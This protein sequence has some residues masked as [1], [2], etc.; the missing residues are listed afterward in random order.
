MDIKDFIKNLADLYEDVDVKEFSP[1]T[2]FKNF[3]EWSSLISLSI[4][5]MA[6]DEYGVTL[7]G[8]DIR[9]ANTVQEL[10][11]IVKSKA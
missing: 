1:E 4:V 3:E 11:D 6:E 8:D 7:K 9:N 2:E 5:A 10:F